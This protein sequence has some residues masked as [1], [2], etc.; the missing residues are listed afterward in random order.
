M[1]CSQH[2][3]IEDIRHEFF[4]RNSIEKSPLHLRPVFIRSEVNSVLIQR[5]IGFCIEF[6]VIRV[7]FYGFP[8]ISCKRI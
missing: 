7:Q 8:I 2:I 6:K 4:V 1:Y 5:P 3:S